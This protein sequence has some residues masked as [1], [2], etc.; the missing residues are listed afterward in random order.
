MQTKYWILKSLLLNFNQ[1]INKKPLKQYL[2]HI[3]IFANLD[4][5]NPFMH[6]AHAAFIEFCK[7]S[8]A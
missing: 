5:Q 7:T 4:S 2:I 3:K 1:R 6:H 8:N